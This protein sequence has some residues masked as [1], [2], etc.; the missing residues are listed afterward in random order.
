ML[1][2]YLITLF[3]TFYILVLGQYQTPFPDSSASWSFQSWQYPDPADPNPNAQ[4]TYSHVTLHAR[5]TIHKNGMVYTRLFADPETFIYMPENCQYYGNLVGY[6]RQEG[7]KVFYLAEQTADWADWAYFSGAD[8]EPQYY[9]LSHFN[10]NDEILL[11]DFGLAV[12]D[13]F[14]ITLYDTIIVE[15]I[16]TVLI[17][18]D[19]LKRFNFDTSSS[20]VCPDNPDD[21]HWIEGIGSNLGYFPYANCFESGGKSLCFYEYFYTGNY[22]YLDSVAYYEPNNG[23]CWYL[24]LGVNELNVDI[25]FEISPNP[26]IDVLDISSSVNVTSIEIY[27]SLGEVVDRRSYNG[28]SVSYDA[29]ELKTGIYFIKIN[30]KVQKFI[31]V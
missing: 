16:D 8:Y 3:S 23:Y 5:D 9:T 15:S 11:Y 13:S 28:L 1:K 10:T 12:G 2:F 17:N 25:D 19:T 22:P 21:Y 24:H 20:S 27:N 14:A 29:S 31:K 18:N 30:Q 7:D 6:H 4:T 26:V